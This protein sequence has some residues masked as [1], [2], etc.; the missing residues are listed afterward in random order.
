[1]KD[2]DYLYVSAFVRT[3]E[4]KMLTQTDFDALLRAPS[5]QD[6]QRYLAQQGY[7]DEKAHLTHV[8]NEVIKA[9]PPGAPVEILL[10]QNDIHN[11]KT[12]LKAIVSGAA[13]EPLMLQPSTVEPQHMHR[14]IKS[15]K[16]EDLPTF[17]ARAT[18]QAH[19]LLTQEQDAQHA[20]TLLDETY[21]AAAKTLATQAKNDFL[22]GF[23]DL[24]ATLAHEQS[25]LR[26][27]DLS[28]ITV[29][30]QQC[31]NRMM[32]YLQHARHK[33]FGIEPVFGFLAGKLLEMKNIRIVLAGLRVG[34]S[35]EQL[36]E[37]LREPYV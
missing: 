22:R 25:L 13:Y 3:L 31:D 30:E 34:L 15:R 4:S 24:T 20:E 14:A 1:M 37:R 27:Q 18:A 16:F 26:R 6:A 17:M 23:V 32:Q 29:F 19:A 9:C 11:C 12:I 33:A 36:R 7:G 8:W 21:F 2:T 28:S 35:A 5:L 10:Y